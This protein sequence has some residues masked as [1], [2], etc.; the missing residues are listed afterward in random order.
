LFKPIHLGYLM[1]SLALLVSACGVPAANP[2]AP[3]AGSTGSESSAISHVKEAVEND[4]V[5]QNVPQELPTTSVEV[6]SN[7]AGNVHVEKSAA[8]VEAT[9]EEILS[10][11]ADAKRSP[12]E[13]QLRLLTSLK[14]QGAAP[15]LHNKV[16]LNSEPLKL[17]DLRG[18][19]V[20][21]EFWTFG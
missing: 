13:G 16:W 9:S 7:E 11:E 17:A 18:K 3:A 8:N 15:E 4:A 21:V 6:A 1:F 2:Q 12:S 5:A 14:S 20:L 19:V 10:E